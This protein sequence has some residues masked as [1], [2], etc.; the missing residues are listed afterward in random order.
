MSDGATGITDAVWLN[1]QASPLVEAVRGYLESEFGDKLVAG[2]T[3]PEDVTVGIAIADDAHLGTLKAAAEQNAGALQTVLITADEPNGGLADFV[4]QD[5]ADLESIKSVVRAAREFREQVLRLRADVAKRKS[6][7]GTINS[8]QFIFKRLDEARNLATMLA[9]ACPQ[10]D[11]VAVGLQELM[12]NAVEHGNLE[13]DAEQKQ[14]LILSNSW[15]DEIDRRLDDPEFRDRIVIVNFQRG[16]R[17]ISITIQD[18]G[19]GFDHQSVATADMP[20]EG[21]RGRGIALARDLSFSSVAY[22]G[23]GN[24]VQAT[25]LIP[26]ADERSD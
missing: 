25:I 19:A 26:A 17:M 7:I 6:A 21:Y 15:R 1:M 12:I 11:V 18:E 20:T 2:D 16:E 22:L 14:A 13:I 5:S 4:L 24:I 3:L 8:G 10:S 9:L 23:A